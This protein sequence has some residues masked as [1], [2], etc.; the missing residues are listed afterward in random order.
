MSG[1]VSQPFNSVADAIRRYLAQRPEAAETV[2]GVAKWWLARQRYD[3][4]VSLVQHALDYLEQQG[5]VEK[6]SVTSGQVFYRKARSVNHAPL[7]NTQ[8]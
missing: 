6:I 5:E 3:D 1:T 2:E 4:S 7:F 8:Q